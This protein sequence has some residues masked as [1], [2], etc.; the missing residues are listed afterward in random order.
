MSISAKEARETND[1]LNLL[2]DSGYILA[3]KPKVQMLFEEIDGIMKILTEEDLLQIVQDK[4]LPAISSL[5]LAHMAQCRH[6]D[7]LNTARRILAQ[8]RISLA[9]HTYSF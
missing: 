2:K 4:G 9:N 8:E 1:W 6:S 5:R 7:I 3:D